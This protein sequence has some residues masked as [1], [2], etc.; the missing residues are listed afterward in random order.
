MQLP[1]CFCLL[2]GSIG[3][4]QQQQQ[5]SLLTVKKARENGAVTQWLLRS[6]STLVG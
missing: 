1:L 4:Q 3:L 2:I 5:R 6:S